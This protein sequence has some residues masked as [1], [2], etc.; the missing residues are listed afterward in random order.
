MVIIPAIDIKDGK[1]VRLLQGDFNR[2]TVYAD[3][4]VEMAKTWRRRGAERLHV[5]DLDGSKEGGPVNGEVI[6]RIARAV[7]VTVQVG[8]GI[9]CMETVE[10]Y[11]TA[12]VGRVILGTAVLKNRDFVIEACR[13]FPGRII[14][15]IDARDGMV[16]VEGWLEQT[17]QSPAELAV[18]YE[19]YGIDAIIYTD[20]GRDGMQT[21]VNL[22]STA[23]LA[24]AA[25]IPV[26]ASGGVSNI[27]DIKRLLSMKDSGIM[28][29]IVGKAL[30]DGRIDLEEAIA[31]A[32]GSG[33]RSVQ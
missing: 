32:R 27:D 4:P 23:Q 30:Y 20:I 15:G 13:C 11:L 24:G 14:L 26:I 12:G 8:G 33:G 22:D 21:G 31:V 9:R 28:G 3:D 6:E 10:R 5:V 25:S 19:G 18:M 17:E 2:V 7:D 16:A 29:V 1:C